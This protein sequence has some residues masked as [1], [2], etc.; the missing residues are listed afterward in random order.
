VLRPM[1]EYLLSPHPENLTRSILK[2]HL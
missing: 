2:P 1:K